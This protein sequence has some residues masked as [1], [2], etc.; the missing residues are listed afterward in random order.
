M[1]SAMTDRSNVFVTK[2]VTVV[3]AVAL[4][5]RGGSAQVPVV[6]NVVGLAPE[7]AAEKLYAAAVEAELAGNG[8]ERNILLRQAVRFSPD[9]PPARW[10]LGEL[11][12]GDAW[13]TVDDAAARWARD[14]RLFEY[15][16]RRNA[17]VDDLA[18]NLALAR[19]AK[20]SALADEAVV[21]WRRVLRDDRGNEEA[22]RS[23]GLRKLNGRYYPHDDYK[24]AAANVRRAK[25]AASRWTPKVAAIRRDLASPVAAERNRGLAELRAIED[26]EALATLQAEFSLADPRDPFRTVDETAAAF[27]RDR[28]WN[29]E[30]V[31][32][33]SRWPEVAATNALVREAVLS[34]VKDV[35]LA[36][37]DV[38]ADRPA[39]HYVPRLLAGLV[40][41]IDA[42]ITL[43]LDGR[44]RVFYRRT[45]FR[46]GPLA[47]AVATYDDFYQNFVVAPVFYAD[48]YAEDVV[49]EE[50]VP[51]AQ[52]DA[53][54]SNAVAVRAAVERTNAH[55]DRMNARIVA[56]ASRATGVDLPAD[57]AT[58][59]RWWQDYNELY[60]GAVKP[61]YERTYANYYVPYPVA[62]YYYP[63]SCFAPGTTVMT[64]V[65]PRPIE[66]IRVG[67]SVLAQNP[68][69][70]ELAFKAVLDRTSRPP[71]PLLAIALGQQT[72]R[73]TRGHPLWIVGE[74]WQMA[75]HL[76]LGD[77]LHS[78]AGPIPIT[79]IAESAPAAT[80]NLV[81]DDWHTYFVSDR[82]VLVHDNAPQRPTIARLPGV[83]R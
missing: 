46:E 27:A 9:F 25:Q 81:V 48:G 24:V 57:A 31:A 75:K 16:T 37:A 30:Y 36:A 7:V 50:P 42:R 5:A 44:G 23:L 20:K 53:L 61:L 2:A 29:L 80:Y 62:G 40:A 12:D 83:P 82:R 26:R 35:R 59:W 64:K 54:A 15:E 4:I 66:T 21:H 47:D 38:L 68:E 56:A 76:R 74:N 65:G 32:L 17:A 10:R 58:W 43:T 71:G 18:N 78:I 67:D 73:V 34:P 60:V 51:R 55:I 52:V 1:R 41:P 13:R 11:R 3:A 19:W 77:R 28:A 8:P 14:P 70:G 72:I 39:H 22:A 6:P 79:Q 49:L 63:V 45:F 69:T 33:L